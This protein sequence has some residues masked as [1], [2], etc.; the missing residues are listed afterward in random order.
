MNSRKHPVTTDPIERAASFSYYPGRSGD[1]VIALKPYWI[2]MESVGTTH[3]SAYEYDQHVPVLFY[4]WGVHHAAFEDAVS[5]L[6]SRQRSPIFAA[7]ACSVRM[8]TLS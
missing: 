8:G 5:P 1:I 7:S 4:G 6:E 3:G 2:Y